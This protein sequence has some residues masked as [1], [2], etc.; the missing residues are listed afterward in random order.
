MC[1]NCFAHSF[2][3]LRTIAVCRECRWCGQLE[4]DSDYSSF[5][6]MDDDATEDGEQ[7]ES[8]PEPEEVVDAAEPEAEPA[9]NCR[10]SS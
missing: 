8:E 10:L 2:H 1:P 3:L 9:Q 6:D 4:W 5:E 7:D